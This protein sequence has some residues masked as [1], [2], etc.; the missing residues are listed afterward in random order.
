MSF[1]QILDTIETLPLYQ[2]EEIIQIVNKR[3]IERKRE[4]IR[5]SYEDAIEDLRKG[6]IKPEEPD[7]FFDRMEN[8]IEDDLQK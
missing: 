5:I 4:N 7:E 1:E 3:I 8:T 6:N 2:Q